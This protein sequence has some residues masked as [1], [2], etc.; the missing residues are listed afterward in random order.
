MLLFGGLFLFVW[1]EWGRTS[2][3]PAGVTPVAGASLSHEPITAPS[4][5][6]WEPSG[7]TRLQTLREST[8]RLVHLQ[9]PMEETE[10]GDWL[11]AHH[12]DGQS[13]EQYIRSK[14]VRAGKK[15]N[16]IYVLPIGSF[17]QAQHE[18]VEK[19]IEFMALFFGLPVKVMEHLDASVVPE[20]ERRVFSASGEQQLYT[21]YILSKVLRPRLP[22]DAVCAIALTAMDLWPGDG[23]NFVFGEAMLKGRV[24]VWSIN[25]FGDP[26]KSPADYRTVLMRTMKTATH[27][28]GHM[29]SI[30]HC[31]AWRCNMN[32]CNNMS[33]SDSTPLWLCAEC[34][35]KVFWATHADP[36][37]SMEGMAAFFERE[38]FA[39]E[40]E[41]ARKST[42]VFRTLFVEQDKTE[43]SQPEQHPQQ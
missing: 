17:T 15:R 3:P 31:I 20:S 28:T 36:V 5:A 27:E 9:L 12:E 33:E 41:V 34:Q 14:P 35:A 11:S 22:D 37:K 21:G 1:A 25:R 42:E 39:V 32:G 26:S 18:V 10:P 7:K 2:P 38:G 40:A 8:K 13:F 30:E 29:F 43:P 6:P 16:C 24:G 19:T 23:W 4:F